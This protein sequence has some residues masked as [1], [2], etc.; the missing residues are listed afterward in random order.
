MLRLGIWLAERPG[1]DD[2]RFTSLF[3]S[4]LLHFDFIHAATQSTSFLQHA[5][6]RRDL[7]LPE[8]EEDMPLSAHKLEKRQSGPQ[9]GPGG[10]AGQNQ[11]SQ[12]DQA[13]EF[14][15]ILLD[16]LSLRGGRGVHTAVEALVAQLKEK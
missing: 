14:E 16:I 7:L 15:G 2:E 8:E 1:L 11:S 12:R 4:F 13:E 6:L 9:S 5:Q 10:N 3:E